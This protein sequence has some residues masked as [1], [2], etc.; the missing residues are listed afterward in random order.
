MAGSGWGSVRRG[1]WFI[2][3]R[4]HFGA[5]NKRDNDSQWENILP[6]MGRG[7]GYGVPGL[8]SGDCLCYYVSVVITYDWYFHTQCA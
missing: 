5:S 2:M 3:E 7:R 8:K 4:N 1:V 6:H